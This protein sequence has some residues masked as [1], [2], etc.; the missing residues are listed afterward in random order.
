MH[1]GVS[2]KIPGYRFSQKTLAR[3]IAGSIKY[4]NEVLAPPDKRVQLFL[5]TGD[6]NP[7]DQAVQLAAAA[8]VSNLNGGDTLITRSNQTLSAIAPL[9]IRKGKAFQIYAPNQNENE[10]TNLWT[11]PFYGYERVIETF[12][13]TDTPRRFKPI[14][15]YYHFYSATKKA[16]LEALKKVYDWALSQPVLPIYASDYAR[17][18]E[19]FFRL[20]VARDGDT[21]R[22]RGAQALRELR[23]DQAMGYP[24]LARSQGIVGFADHGNDRYVHLSGEEEVV[25]A[26]TQQPPSAPYLVESDAP[27]RRWKQGAGSFEVSLAGPRSVTY[28]MNRSERCRLHPEGASTRDSALGATT[29]PR[30]GRPTRNGSHSVTITC[31]P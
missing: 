31:R 9:G 16:S 18:V 8:G 13:L 17:K 5:W 26:L 25:L 29:M 24:D 30:Q 19:D 10:Y 22:I 28:V 21:W 23:I 4:V 7:S 15:I 20:V 27:I 11:G 3:E 6:T 14:N 1:Y 2:L 12:E